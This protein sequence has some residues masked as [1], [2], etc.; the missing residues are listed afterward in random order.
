MVK[1][2][3]K[4]NIN[5][6]IIFVLI[7][8]IIFSL[9]NCIIM[10]IDF[11]VEKSIQKVVQED[12]VYLVD[13]DAHEKDYYQNLFGED[14]IDAGIND[15]K[16]QY[17][18]Y[19]R[20]IPIFYVDDFEYEDECIMDYATYVYNNY[21]DEV[22]V[23][24]QRIKDDNADLPPIKVNKNHFSDIP[25]VFVS[26]KY[27]YENSSFK[28]VQYYGIV[29]NDKNINNVC[30][31]YDLNN[32]YNSLIAYYGDFQYFER[33]IDDINRKEIQLEKVSA[34][35]A[36]AMFIIYFLIYISFVDKNIEDYRLLYIYGKSKTKIILFAFLIPLLS[37]LFSCAL[38][39]IIN[40]T[41]L[42][43]YN[44]YYSSQLCIGIGHNVLIMWRI[45]LIFTFI[46]ILGA[47][48]YLQKQLKKD[49]LR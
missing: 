37:Y 16:N 36:L 25:G 35:F 10:H 26:K 6:L 40:L 4:K 21:P 11:N 49:V 27:L 17:Y 8:T 12:E 42:N 24:G 2:Y 34:L 18:S 39:F 46:A 15:L 13:S 30:E 22:R 44:T 5:F 1:K 31:Y 29:V 32:R 48:I 33:A 7:N 45:I 19:A 14:I 3:C 41:Y 9:T 43:I 38:T 20:D 23:Y 28:L 47:T